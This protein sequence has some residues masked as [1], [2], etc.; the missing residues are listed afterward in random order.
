MDVDE[1]IWK[2][3]NH[4]RVIKKDRD[5]GFEFCDGCGR[6]FKGKQ[7]VAV[8]KGFRTA[9]WLGLSQV[10][11]REP[12]DQSRYTGRWLRYKAK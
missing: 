5:V 3:K 8:H 12:W 1:L 2:A 11:E 4:N 7:G 10:V 9:C 6:R